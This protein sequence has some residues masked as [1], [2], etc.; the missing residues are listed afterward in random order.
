MFQGGGG[1]QKGTEGKAEVK[2]S[3]DVHP[4]TAVWLHQNQQSAY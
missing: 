1:S 2:V 3:G 4:G